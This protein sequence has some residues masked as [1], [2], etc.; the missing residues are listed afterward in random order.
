MLDLGPKTV[1]LS[2]VVSSLPVLTAREK[3][4][5]CTSPICFSSGSLPR[6]PVAVM[7]NIFCLVVVDVH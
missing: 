3:A 2:Q 4:A 7:L 5:A 6:F 1:Q